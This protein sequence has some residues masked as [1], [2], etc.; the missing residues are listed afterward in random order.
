MGHKLEGSNSMGEHKIQGRKT[1]P[2][3]TMCQERLMDEQMEKTNCFKKETNYEPNM[4][5]KLH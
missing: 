2:V 3:L 4:E 5:N 1:S